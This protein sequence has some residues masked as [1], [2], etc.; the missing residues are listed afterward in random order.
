[1]E[2]AMSE[3]YLINAAQGIVSFSSCNET[4]PECVLSE[5]SSMEILK[6][7]L[8]VF[9]RMGD[10]DLVHCIVFRWQKKPGGIFMI[11][12]RDGILF[13]AIARDNLSFAAAC[14]YFGE[15][16]ANNR[17]GVDIF[18]ELQEPND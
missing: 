9:C 17:Y 13:A 10:P 6:E 5:K 3:T 12:D 4:I 8:S 7:G 2:T 16:T 18:E 11:H 1:M 15:I 14:G